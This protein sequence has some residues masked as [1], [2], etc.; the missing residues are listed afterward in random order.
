[1]EE[2]TLVSIQC[3]VYNHEPYLRQCLDG[4]VMQKTDF[5]FEVIV[6]DDCSTDDSANII[7][8]YAEKYPEIIKPILEDNNQYTKGGF[9]LISKIITEYTY[10]KYVAMCEGDDYWTDPLKL[11]KQVLVLEKNQ[12]VN[13]VYTNFR[14]VD[15]KGNAINRSY[16]ENIKRHSP[17]GDIFGKLME[18]NY[19]LTLTTCFRRDV[20]FTEQYKNS[21]YKYDYT[22][23]CEAS[24]TGDVI[25]LEDVTGCYRQSPNGAMAT[26][27]NKVS[28]DI[29]EVFK[30]YASLFYCGY[31]RKRSFLEK[32]RIRY[33]ILNGTLYNKQFLV[34]VLKKD[35]YS[36]VLI[37]FVIVREFFVRLFHKI[38]III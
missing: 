31:G 27:K 28:K 38:N 3:L 22:L 29:F 20:F 36:D 30:Y 10:G 14:N 11:Q 23:A 34:D 21:P 32:I 33:Y 4:F 7:R 16:Y 1:M 35:F 2:K 24:I 6:H 15:F 19:I 5:K 13:L 8:D 37:V 25:Y 18:K 26:M 17:S 12:N 9:G